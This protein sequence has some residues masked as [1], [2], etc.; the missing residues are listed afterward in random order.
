MNKK[1]GTAYLAPLD[2]ENQVLQTTKGVVAK[3]NNLYLTNL[4]PQPIYWAQN[5][6]YD[7]FIASFDSISQAASILKDIQR[8]WSLFPYSEHRRAELISAKL[9]YISSKPIRFP[10]ETPKAPMGSW[11]LLDKNTLLA[12]PTC[13]SY[14]SNGILNFEEIKEGPPSRAYLK[15]WE[16]LTLAGKLPGPGEKCLEVGSSPGGWT[17]VIAQ[18]GASVLSVDRT[19]LA[20]QVAAMPGVVFKKG[21][22]FSMTP[23]VVGG[24][25]WIFSDVACYPEKLLEWVQLWI[26]SGLCKNFICTLKFQADN[27]YEIVNE[28]AKIA[29][30]H[31]VHLGHNKHELT[32]I[33]IQK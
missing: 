4:E 33:F 22:A 26:K 13:S 19:E 29:G 17:W 5:I 6:W 11:M 20:P 9:P 10:T 21:N 8:N 15:L 16:A 14:Y 23:D 27:S 7:P 12:S 28:F 32:W 30:S 24:V 31:I 3:Y 25:D 18:L 2:Y 1:L